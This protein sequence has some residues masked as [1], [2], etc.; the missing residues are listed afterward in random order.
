MK[1]WEMIKRSVQGDIWYSET[2]GYSIIQTSRGLVSLKSK[3]HSIK[4]SNNFL[5]ATDW[6]KI[7]KDH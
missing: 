7:N 1:T 3:F 2:L 6:K 4:A 5:R